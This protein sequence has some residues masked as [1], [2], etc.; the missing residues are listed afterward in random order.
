MHKYVC[1]GSHW[2]KCETIKRWFWSPPTIW[3]SFALLF[4]FLVNVNKT[5]T[6]DSDKATR[7]QLLIIEMEGSGWTTIAL[8][9]NGSL[10]QFSFSEWM[11][12]LEKLNICDFLWINTDV[13]MTLVA[14]LVVFCRCWCH[15]NCSNCSRVLLYP[16][17]RKSSRYL[18]ITYLTVSLPHPTNKCCTFEIQIVKAR[19]L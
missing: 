13:I 1:Y 12:R 14:D 3:R 10:L 15:N 9:T 18:S 16:H 8:T 7:L 2:V 11:P 17:I 19:K 4:N 5:E 6:A